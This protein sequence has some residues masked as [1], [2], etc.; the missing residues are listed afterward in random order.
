MA[1]ITHDDLQRRLDGLEMLAAEWKSLSEVI[2]GDSRRGITGVL[3]AITELRV[4]VIKLRSAIQYLRLVS[5]ML[6]VMMV[7]SLFTLFYLVQVLR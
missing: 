1:P 5:A 2:Y 7:F 4:E 6:F 3:P